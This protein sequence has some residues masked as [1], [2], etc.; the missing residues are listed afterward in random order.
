MRKKPT[1]PID[2][3]RA[4]WQ[5]LYRLMDTALA[6]SKAA[7]NEED[8]R[9]LRDALEVID[10]AREL[11]ALVKTMDAL[12][13]EGRKF[14]LGRKL[15]TGGPIRRA[16]KRALKSQPAMK[17]PE[18]W[19]SIAATPPRGWQFFDNR[20]GKYVEGPTASQIMSYARFCNVCAEERK[21]M[22]GADSSRDSE[23]VK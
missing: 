16:I 19:E 10:H 14:K 5:G 21:A 22:T 3:I 4:T 7:A 18:I 15:N 9:R 11:M 12:A 23:P 20:A 6:H 2:G 8:F 13:F 1:D 17:N